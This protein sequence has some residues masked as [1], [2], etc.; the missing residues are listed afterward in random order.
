MFDNNSNSKQQQ[1]HRAK[2]SRGD[3]CCHGWMMQLEKAE[4]SSYIGN[5]SHAHWHSPG[6]TEKD[7][8]VRQPRKGGK[9]CSTPSMH[10]AKNQALEISLEKFKTFHVLFGFFWGVK[11]KQFR[12]QII[13]INITYFY[14][15]TQYLALLPCSAILPPRTRKYICGNVAAPLRCSSHFISTLSTLVAPLN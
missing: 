12:L 10:W 6:E 2:R 13:I 7:D 9:A 1:R 5:K 15:G 8:T 4:N 11:P 14:L 3:D